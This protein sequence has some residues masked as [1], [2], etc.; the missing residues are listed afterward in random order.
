[1]HED[2]AAVERYITTVMP[3]AN[4][5]ISLALDVIMM[6][7]HTIRHR[8]TSYS[9]LRVRKGVSS[10]SRKYGRFK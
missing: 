8:R 3:P 2:G 9:V 10:L 5:R 1:M 7:L 4:A 6:N